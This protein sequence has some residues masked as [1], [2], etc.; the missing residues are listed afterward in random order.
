MV[1]LL[2]PITMRLSR[3]LYLNMFVKF[4][5]GSSINS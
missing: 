5:K 1:L 4:G 3:V 2:Q